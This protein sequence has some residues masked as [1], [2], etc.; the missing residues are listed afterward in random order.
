[1]V[2]GSKTSF[3]NNAVKR[4]AVDV[5]RLRKTY[6][7]DGMGNRLG[8]PAE[9]TIAVKII[10]DNIS[11]KNLQNRTIGQIVPGTSKIYWDADQDIIEGDIL[12]YEE[13]QW[14]L[15]KITSEWFAVFSEGEVQKLNLKG[16]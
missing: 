1:M 8:T 7:K 13:I 5:S 6:E 12:I 10:F 15:Q 2:I 16:S 3:K 11:K 9:E 14:K 4:L